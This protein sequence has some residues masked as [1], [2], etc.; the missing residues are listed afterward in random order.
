MLKKTDKCNALILAAGRSGRMGFPKYLLQFDGEKTFLEHIVNQYRAFGCKEI[1]VVLNNEE[2]ES[3]SKKG[4]SPRLKSVIFVRNPHP[5][6][7]RFYS[8]Q[9][10]L[11]SLSDDNPVF[12]HNVDNP[13]APAEVLQKLFENREEGDYVVPSFHGRGGHPVLV[14]P[15]VVRAIVDEKDIRHNLKDFLSGFSKVAVSVDD[16][17]VLLNIN[18]EEDYRKFRERNK[19]R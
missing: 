5:D 11:R 3:F 17:N 13:F 19:L 10:G 18:T 8:V 16:E 15:K 6:R 9:L 12:L 14:N 7:E 4:L 2:A 1:T